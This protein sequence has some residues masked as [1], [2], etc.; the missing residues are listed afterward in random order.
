ME[1]R[2]T[3]LIKTGYTLSITA[4]KPNGPH[5]CVIDLEA[6]SSNLP[7]SRVI[8]DKIDEMTVPGIMKGLNDALDWLGPKDG[9]EYKNTPLSVFIES[10]YEIYIKLNKDLLHG[11]RSF[12]SANLNGC[13]A[14]KFPIN[15]INDIKSSDV[16]SIIDRI[17]DI[18]S[19]Y[20]DR[21]K[22]E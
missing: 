5:A 19:E 11:N 15:N 20:D 13:P 6:G 22:R 10:G 8:L 14:V 12:I 4:N 16:S 3:K 18:I 9:S 21:L 17:V 7:S 2:L 1:D